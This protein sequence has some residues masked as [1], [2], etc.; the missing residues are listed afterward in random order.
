MAHEEESLP[1]AVPIYARN[2]RWIGGKPLRCYTQSGVVV[3]PP[4]PP[5]VI[6]CDAQRPA[7]VKGAPGVGAA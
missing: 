6:V 3:I 1:V 2:G 7:A 4:E 5:V